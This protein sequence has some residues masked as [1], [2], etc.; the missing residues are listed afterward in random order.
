MTR[1]LVFS[2]PAFGLDS[3][4]CRVRSRPP[5]L[6]AVNAWLDTVVRRESDVFS[7]EGPI[8]VKLAISSMLA[9]CVPVV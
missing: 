6:R 2:C 8:A 9:L 4:A 7:D 3:L 5:L 1:G